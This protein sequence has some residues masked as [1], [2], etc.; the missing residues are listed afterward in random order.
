MHFLWKIRTLILANWLIASILVLVPFHAFLTVWGST[1][2][3]HFV[4]LRLWDEVVFALLVV[5]VGSMLW[6]DHK[7]VRSLA[8]NKLVQ[9]II[10][11]IALTILWGLGSLA[12]HQ[13]TLTALA[14]AL[15]VNLR[16]LV[17]FLAVWVVAVKSDWL[18]SHWLKLIMIPLVITL[19]IALLQFF[20]LPANFLTH[21]GYGP[22]TF[23]PGLTLNQDSMLLRVQAT[24]RGS[25][26]FGAYLATPVTVLV[27]FAVA[28]W[29]RWKYPVVIAMT[30][31]VLVI[32]FS[33]SA[34]LAAGLAVAIV[35]GARIPRALRVRAVV[36]AACVVVIGGL[37]GAALLQTSPGFQDVILHSNDRS[38]TIHTSNAQHS[39]ALQRAVRTIIQNPLGN[40]PGSSGQ[41]SEYNSGHP[42][43]NPESLL[44]QIG[45]E[46]GWL[47]LG[48]FLAV[49]VQLGI[50]LWSRRRGALPLA[51][52]ASLVGLTL[53][54]LVTYTWV[55]DTVGFIWWGLAA[56]ALTT[57]TQTQDN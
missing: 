25:N 45:E 2:V 33:R 24:M 48:L 26:Q 40:G 38:T 50:T 36:A 7:L 39:S 5:I 1:F 4:L 28:S 53:I 34:W 23:V 8:T 35:I 31:V 52:F 21:F 51:M 37:I 29:R 57:R 6:R 19:L 14:Y 16:F 54:G 20:A 44:L 17:W 10:G 42:Y 11:Y 32:T 13:V 56:L 9:L 43:R 27:S 3:G 41:A 15:V 46:T 18:S 55:D 49:L 22:R 30:G 12:L 47:G